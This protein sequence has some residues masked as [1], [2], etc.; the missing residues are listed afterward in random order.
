MFEVGLNLVIESVLWVVG[1][2]LEKSWTYVIGFVYI[3]V[4]YTGY[5]VIVLLDLCI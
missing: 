3:S 2:V 4:Y 1:F 5:Y